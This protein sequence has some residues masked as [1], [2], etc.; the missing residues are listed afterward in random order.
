MKLP[1]ILFAFV[2][3][4]AFCGL[5]GCASTTTAQD[6]QVLTV[7]QNTVTAAETAYTLALDAGVVPA[8]DQAIAALAIP[9]INAGLTAAQAA[10]AAGDANGFQV[11]IAAIEAG[12][13]K[14]TPIIS[15]AQD[16]LRTMYKIKRSPTKT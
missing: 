2:S 9:A 14:L 6:Q 12:V 16:A 3:L 1:A 11:A 10:I 7:I 8:Q 13:G 5:T 15:T 4:F